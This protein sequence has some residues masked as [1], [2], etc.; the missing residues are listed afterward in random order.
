MLYLARFRG[1]LLPC[2][3][4]STTDDTE[5]LAARLEAEVGERP[6]ELREVPLD[7]VCCEVRFPDPPDAEQEDNPANVTDDAVLDPFELFATWLDEADAAPL[8]GALALVPDL[9]TAPTEPP[10][11]C[12]D[13]ATDGH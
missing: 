2:L 13:G 11:E 12:D 10:E 3:V 4:G 9:A 8:P 1:D 7:V 5:E 6:A